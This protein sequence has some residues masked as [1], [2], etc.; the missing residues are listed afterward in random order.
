VYS[1]ARWWPRGIRQ[2]PRFSSAFCPHAVRAMHFTPGTGSGRGRRRGP[3]RRAILTRSGGVPAE[4]TGPIA[5]SMVSSARPQTPWGTP[6]AGLRGDEARPEGT[7]QES[8]KP[9]CTNA[10]SAAVIHGGRA[11]RPRTRITG[12]RKER[13]GPVIIRPGRVAR[14][15]KPQIAKPNSMSE[16]DQEAPGRHCCATDIDPNDG[17][18]DGDPCHQHR[19]GT[20]A[21]EA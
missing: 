4:Q 3:G 6:V 9:N 10:V 15:V 16:L 1:W 2:T 21:R 18:Q 13:D 20:R 14:V 8:Q 11:I 5:V 12:T 19:V 17:R 7:L